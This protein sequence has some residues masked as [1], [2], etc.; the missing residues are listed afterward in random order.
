MNTYNIKVNSIDVIKEI[1]TEDLDQQLRMIRG[2]LS[3]I[4]REDASVEVVLNNTEP[5]CKK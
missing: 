5:P 1:N 2:Y 4:G 3:V